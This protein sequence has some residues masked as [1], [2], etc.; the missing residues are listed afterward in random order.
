MLKL[1][2]IYNL[3]LIEISIPCQQTSEYPQAKL[4]REANSPPLE[5]KTATK[6]SA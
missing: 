5:L 6:S 3:R 2:K 4:N 1:I